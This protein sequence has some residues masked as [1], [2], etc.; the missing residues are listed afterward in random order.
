MCFTSPFRPARHFRFPCLLIPPTEIGDPECGEG[1][2]TDC[3][4][5]DSEH[6][7]VG[8]LSVPFQLS[9]GARGIGLVEPN[10]ARNGAIKGRAGLAPPSE[11]LQGLRLEALAGGFDE[12]ALGRLI[13]TVVE[14]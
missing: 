9:I 14:A 5:D 13:R 7:V 8:A 3:F 10:E 6:L 2:L 12:T 1:S 11:P 4:L